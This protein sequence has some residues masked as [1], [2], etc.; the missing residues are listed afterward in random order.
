MECFANACKKMKLTFSWILLNYTNV[1]DFLNCKLILPEIMEIDRTVGS[2]S[3]RSLVDKNGMARQFLEYILQDSISKITNFLR[4]KIFEIYLRLLDRNT[5]A[6]ADIQYIYINNKYLPLRVYAWFRAI[7]VIEI[8]VCV[9][10]FVCGW[11][12]RWK[13]PRR[14][15]FSAPR[16]YVGHKI[17][18]VHCLRS[19]ASHVER[20]DKDANWIRRWW[21]FSDSRPL[22][23]HSP[24]SHSKR[25]KSIH[26]PM[27]I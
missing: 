19:K 4:Y 20:P 27:Q 8:A 25:N 6:H 17:G 1:M 12:E 5:Y 14:M 21:C 18:C 26:T 10:V 15:S 11:R 23:P 24:H 7:M 16:A 9:C 2:L 3:N 13:L 22:S